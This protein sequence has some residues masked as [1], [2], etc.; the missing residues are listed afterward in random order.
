MG[1]FDLVT[2]GGTVVTASDLFRADIGTRGGR[3]AALADPV[4]GGEREINASSL[5][6]LPGGIDSHVHVAQPS[7]PEGHHGRRFRVGYGG[8]RTG[9]NTTVLPFALQQRGTSLRTCAEEYRRLAEWQCYIDTAFHLIIS[10]TTAEV[11]GQELPALVRAGFTS[12]KVFMTYDDMVLND[13]HVLIRK[14]RAARV[15]SPPEDRRDFGRVRTAP[16]DARQPPFNNE[17][18]PLTR[19]HLRR[20]RSQ[21]SVR[22]QPINH[23]GHEAARVRLPRVSGRARRKAE[24]GVERLVFDHEHS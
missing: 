4:A 15:W 12:F 2:R 24:S 17:Q 16:L 14:R 22:H 21:G 11:L 23:V 8:G 9:G 5:H 20:E 6:V 3:I 1:D 13:R 10:D 19:F 18:H 7:G